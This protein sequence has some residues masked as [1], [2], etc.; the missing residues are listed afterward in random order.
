M[1]ATTRHASPVSLRYLPGLDG[2]RGV[3]VMAVI[4]THTVATIPGGFL[5]VDVFFALSGYLVT[6]LLIT[7]WHQSDRISLGNFWSRRAR[8]LLPA[9]FLML[10][11]V[12]AGAALWPQIFGSP[13]LRGD[14][15]ATVFYVANWH[16]I[17]DHT[18]YFLAAGR[19]SPLLHTWS[20]A[21]EE[22]FYLVWPIVV[23]AVLTLRRARAHGPASSPDAVDHRRRSHVLFVVATGGAVASAVWMAVLT[24]GGG[25]TTRSFYASDTR[26]QAILV[27]AAL[28]VGS[29]LW[30]PARSRRA[31]LR[32]G[33]GERGSWGRPC[34][35]CSSPR[36][37]CRCSAVAF[38]PPPCARLASSPVSPTSPPVAWRRCCRGRPSLRGPHLLRHVPLV[39]AAR[40]RVV[41]HSHPPPGLPPP[42][43]PVG[44]DHR[45]GQRLGLPRRA[46]HPPGPSPGMVA[47]LAMPVAASLAVL[48]TFLATV[49]VSDV[50]AASVRADAGPWARR[51]TCVTTTTY[52]EPV[53]VLIVGDSVAGT[54]GVGLR[55]VMSQYGVLAV[56]EGSPGCSV[57]MD[58]LVKVLW[59]TDPP[60]MPYMNGD[61][62][63]LFTQWR[64][65]F[66]QYDPDVVIYIARTT[67]WSKRSI[68]PGPTSACR[69]STR[70]SR[71]GSARRS[72]SSA[73]AARTWSC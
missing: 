36:A 61:P 62:A 18:N 55:R 52:P 22:Q 33:V 17:A 30:G 8:R 50:A 53:K 29:T 35:G 7:E 72:T 73:R 59:F 24:H 43:G 41:G 45:R 23:L 56:N 37:R 60:G 46:A 47:P 9:L 1:R 28:A 34:C 44:G 66:D 5:S 14:T 51:D 32:C 48:T 49:G 12:G 69:R 2:I 68:R 39:L 16:F 15:L 65:W 13:S 6:A 38:S 31:A 42:R 11:V 54:L 26:A 64:A 71:T 3:A 70:T 20:L 25:D 27:G 63:A 40:A 21:I 67:Y 57:S 4:A 58:Q 10:T 19:A